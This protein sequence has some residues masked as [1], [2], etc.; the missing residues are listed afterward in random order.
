MLTSVRGPVRSRWLAP[1]EITLDASL[2]RVQNEHV[3]LGTGGHARPRGRAV[4]TTSLQR[5]R[6][7]ACRAGTP[8]RHS[9]FPRNEGV[10]GSSPGVGF[11]E[12]P[13]QAGL[14]LV[15]RARSTRL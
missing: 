13:A 12:S 4:K 6:P 10:P 7:L 14:F 11:R 15:P 2:E 1:R 5:E 9:S 8:V 3:S